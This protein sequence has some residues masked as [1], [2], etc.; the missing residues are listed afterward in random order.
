MFVRTGSHG[1][2]VGRRAVN[3]EVTSQRQRDMDEVDKKKQ[4]AGSRDQ[5]K[6]IKRNNQ[7]F[8]TM[9]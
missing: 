9:V 4:T 6:H 5:V 3:E 1:R 2:G 7:L 8:V